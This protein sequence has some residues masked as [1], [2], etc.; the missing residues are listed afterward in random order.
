MKEPDRY[1]G[2]CSSLPWAPSHANYEYNEYQASHDCCMRV[3][4]RVIVWAWVESP[5]WG[6]LSCF[7]ITARSAH[8]PLFGEL[9]YTQLMLG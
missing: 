7:F 6:E 2:P 4:V 1:T 9:S 3:I 5:S 8:A